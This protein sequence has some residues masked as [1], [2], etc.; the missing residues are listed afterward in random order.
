M[1]LIDFQY[2]TASGSKREERSGGERVK[3]GG[4]RRG[5]CCECGEMNWEE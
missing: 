5:M 2:H 4:E 3:M 1:W